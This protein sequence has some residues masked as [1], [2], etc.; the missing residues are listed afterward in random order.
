MWIFTADADAVA[1]TGGT[2][3]STL[4]VIVNSL[5]THCVEQREKMKELGSKV[6]MSN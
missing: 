6:C 5:F 1:S 2:S 4:V 3:N